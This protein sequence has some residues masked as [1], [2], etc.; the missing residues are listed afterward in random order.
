MSA[1]AVNKTSRA[2]TK[3]EIDIRELIIR[4]QSIAEQG[5]IEI[6]QLAIAT[7]LDEIKDVAA[8]Y[9]KN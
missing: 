9:K 4:L 6:V 1:L 5:N 2:G 7:M 3:V 8:C